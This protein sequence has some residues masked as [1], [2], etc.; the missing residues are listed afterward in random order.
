M[1]YARVLIIRSVHTYINRY[2]YT[3]HY[4][5]LHLTIYFYFYIGNWFLFIN[6]ITVWYASIPTCSVSISSHN[7]FVNK[8]I[9]CSTINFHFV[10]TYSESHTISTRSFSVTHLCKGLW[11]FIVLFMVSQTTTWKVK[12]SNIRYDWYV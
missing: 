10:H 6:I 1:Y 3:L 4:K 7:M 2:Y 5:S 8:T 12:F 11:I 9:V